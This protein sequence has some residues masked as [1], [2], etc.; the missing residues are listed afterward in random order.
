MLRSRLARV[1]ASPNASASLWVSEGALIVVPEARD[2]EYVA[3]GC[4]VLNIP[5][6]PHFYRIDFKEG[7]QSHVKE[8]FVLKIS[9]TF[10]GNTEEWDF[11]RVAGIHRG[12]Y[13][14]VSPAEYTRHI[15]TNYSIWIALRQMV[16]G[17]FL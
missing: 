15:S 6:C 7:S 17:K 12:T 11:E 13:L 4:V 8:D 9:G 16:R 10:L 1:L 2:L 5:T 3:I 14:K